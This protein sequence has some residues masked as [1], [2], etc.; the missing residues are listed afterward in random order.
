MAAAARRPRWPAMRSVVPRQCSPALR[1]CGLASAHDAP[2]DRAL[3]PR[4]THA[5]LLEW[6]DSFN[7]CA[8]FLEKL[9]GRSV[10]SPDVLVQRL[11]ELQCSLLSLKSRLIAEARHSVI[12]RPV[13]R[14]SRAYSSHTGS[15]SVTD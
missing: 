7:D 10:E 13:I 4:Q 5:D 14:A 8:R 11:Q 9:A 2:A 15:G 3:D 1:P 6:P 12:E